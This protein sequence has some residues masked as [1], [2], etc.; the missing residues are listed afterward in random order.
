[1]D[2]E[3]P[4]LTLGMTLVLRSGV[5]ERSGDSSKYCLKTPDA[6]ESPLLSPTMTPYIPVIPSVNEESNYQLL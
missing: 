6:C 1:M 2:S 5:G 3:D 4:S